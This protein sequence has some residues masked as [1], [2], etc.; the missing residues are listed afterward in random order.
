MTNP[1]RPN[2]LLLL[3][4]QW[5]GD[6]LGV[7]GHPDVQTPFLDTLAN[8]GVRFDRAY[9]AVP[10]CI[11]ARAAILTGMSQAHHGRLGYQDGVRWNYPNTLPECFRRAGYQTHCVGKMHV[12]PLRSRLGFDDIDL[13]DGFLHYYNHAN[14]PHSTHQHVA[15]DYCH[16]IDGLGHKTLTDSG[17][18]CNG[19]PAR[20]WPYEEALHPT[21]WVG[22][23]T[24]DFLRRRDRS[25]P[26][27]LTASFVRPHPPFDAPEAYFAP[28]RQMDLRPPIAGDNWGPPPGPTRKSADRA[29][30]DPTAMR[31][32]REG[33]Y[34]C[35][36]QV[37]HQIGRIIEALSAENVLRNTVILFASDHGELLGDHNLF[38]KALPY[39]GSAHVPM[40]MAGPGIPKG[41]ASDS[42]MELMDIMPTLLD[43]AGLEIPD[44]VDG[45]SALPLLQGVQGR[46]LVHGEHAYGDQSN[47][48]LVSSWDK[49]IWY[50]QTG[51]EQYFNLFEDP[52]ELHDAIN[53]SACRARVDELRGALVKTLAGREEGYS[54]GHSL[55]PG[56]PVQSILSFLTP[57]ADR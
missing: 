22:D 17:L 30:D 44:T 24:V 42:V 45:Q 47:H 51:K 6:C 38:R 8:D 35:I 12:H 27:F 29:P 49:Y 20:P 18:E 57:L 21:R 55:I 26:F 41:V 13:H 9:S 2:V 40:L 32:A 34:A 43:A 19:W 52:M 1:D 48:Y 39:E 33:Y 54:D 36:T 10:S 14:V 16:Y 25:A 3:A 37:D 46:E 23:K 11:A 5:R 50:S 7:Y 15:D 31:L 56:R 28:Y 53:D 4:D